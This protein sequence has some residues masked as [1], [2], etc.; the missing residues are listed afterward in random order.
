MVLRATD[1]RCVGRAWEVDL[2]LESAT[3][4]QLDS[5]KAGPTTVNRLVEPARQ[6]RMLTQEPFR[7]RFDKAPTGSTVPVDVCLFDD[8]E[9]RN[10]RPYRCC[11]ARI[12]FQLPR[13]ACGPS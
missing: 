2:F 5:L 1:F 9:S 13:A 7:L 6:T 4:R 10:A 11:R 12:D 8:A 3:G